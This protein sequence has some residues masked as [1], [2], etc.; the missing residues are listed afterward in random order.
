MSPQCLCVFQTGPK[1]GTRCTYAAR[2]GSKFCGY[3]Q[4]CKKEFDGG[5][6]AQ[7]RQL[8]E[9][10][11]RQQAAQRRQPPQRQQAMQRQQ[12]A[13]RQQLP[14]LAEPASETGLHSLD[15]FIKVNEIQNVD[16]LHELSPADID[17]L[18]SILELHDRT[19]KLQD[20]VDAR[21]QELDEDEL[22]AELRQLKIHEIK[23]KTLIDTLAGKLCRCIKKVADQDK[24][25]SIAM[26]INTIFNRRGLKIHR[27][28]CD[29]GPL[30]LPR[31]DQKVVL[32]KQ[33]L[34]PR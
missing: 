21:V 19:Q 32:S 23:V 16:D 3:H 29:A 10:V 18:I 11:Q 12:P 31:K 25:R 14:Q 4:A 8:A 28:Q 26:C 17:H 15:E 20:V 2:S 22:S 30:L 6:P 34:R 5:V 27:W 7:P 13:Q 33:P 24:R 1:R 9:V